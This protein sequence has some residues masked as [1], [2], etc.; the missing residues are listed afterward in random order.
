MHTGDLRRFMS[1]LFLLTI[2]S[3]M[4]MAQDSSKSGGPEPALTIFGKLGAVSSFS[5][6][7]NDIR[8]MPQHSF[9][10]IDPWD[11]KKHEFTGVLLADLLARAGICNKGHHAGGE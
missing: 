1:A 10:T 4:S 2:V 7:E 6:S 3:L 8:A 9:S 11:G 5:Y